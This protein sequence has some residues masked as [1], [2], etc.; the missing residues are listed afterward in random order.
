MA[1]D[2]SLKALYIKVNILRE[3]D[4]KEV[5]QEFFYPLV[6]EDK[7]I[8]LYTS[9]IGSILKAA[10]FGLTANWPNMPGTKLEEGMKSQLLYLWISLANL[11]NPEIYQ[12]TYQTQVWYS[13]EDQIVERDGVKYRE[14]YGYS[15][16]L[17][18]ET[19]NLFIENELPF[20]FTFNSS[21][22]ML[23]K[24]TPCQEGHHS[25]N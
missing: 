3:L 13:F 10:P 22:K 18:E 1:F 5:E 9:N 11:E 20:T 4:K 14:T 6:T 23:I 17:D 2:S 19:E 16:I 7:K 24:S 21:P 12:M 15:K 25:G 8:K